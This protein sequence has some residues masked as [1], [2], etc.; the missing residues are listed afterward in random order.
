MGPLARG[1]IT[2][3]YAK[4]AG[5]SKGPQRRERCPGGD[6]AACAGGAA[7]AGAPDTN[8]VLK[9]GD[10]HLAAGVSR[11]EFVELLGASPLFQHA[12]SSSR[13]YIRV[14]PC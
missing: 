2:N 8:S 14:A 3:R 6:S 5:R 7:W 1:A 12:V 11:E 9:S 13:S 10:R 4:P